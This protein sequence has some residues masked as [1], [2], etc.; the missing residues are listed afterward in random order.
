MT[1][2]IGDTRLQIDVWS[3]IMCPFCYLGDAFL[4]KALEQF[5][6]ADKVDVRYRS[7]Q[8]MPHLPS[9][10]PVD[11]TELL[12]RE[13]GFSREK[14]MAMNAQ[15]T[16]RGKEAGLDY[17]FD[18]ALAVNTRASHRLSHFAAQYGKQHELML[19][20]FRAYFTDGLHL[21]RHDVLADLAAE[22][23]LDR[24]AAL[25]ALESNAFE[26]DVKADER[27][28]RELGVQGVPLF[29]L[30]GKYAV[31][32]AQPVG[33]FLNAL[34]TAWGSGSTTP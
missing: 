6:H 11:L 24:A 13:K 20:L 7:Y 22:V 3:D 21:G 27:E 14:A 8:L 18:R 5:P 29:V 30:N 16:A 26:A 34:N 23:G 33:A 19:R 32:G 1:N 15:I 12:V 28:G 31:S 25:E 10:T 17:R 4:A 9:D 2:A